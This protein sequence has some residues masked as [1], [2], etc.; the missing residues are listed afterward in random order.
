M[1]LN[2]TQRESGEKMMD[3]LPYKKRV[4]D[5]QYRIVLQTILE[6]G[7][8]SRSAHEESSITYLSPPAMRFDLQNGF[9]MIT[10]RTMASK[11]MPI[12]PW[13]QAI[14]EIFAFINGVRTIDEL[15]QFGCLWWKPWG[16]EEKCKKRGLP[17]GDLGPGSYGPAFAAFPT[18]EDESFNQIEAVI[19]QIKERPNL[20]TH[21]ITPW[22]PFYTIRLKNRV[23]KVVVC[24]CHG[25]MYFRVMDDK[26]HLVMSQRS[27]DVPVGV[28]ANMIQYAALLLAMSHVTGYS[29]GMY[30]HTI[31]DAHIYN[32]QVENVKV[33]LG[34]KPRKFPT[35]VLTDPPDNIFEFR[36]EH[37]ILSDYEPH[38]GMKIPVAI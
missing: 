10:E 30:I 12:P 33:M 21:Y 36:R 25:F 34:R 4:S 6:D 24:P 38:P 23:Q 18:L 31:T 32:E 29:P 35:V 8:K 5:L 13:Q 28:P 26:L 3:Y 11:V 7:Q 1:N 16:T 14:G 37:F 9:P 20:R 17:T 19:Q 27:G 15:E 2:I 22:I